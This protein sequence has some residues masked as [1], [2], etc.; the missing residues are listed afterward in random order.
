MKIVTVVGARPQFVKMGVVNRTL[1]KAGVENVVVHTGQH[2][3]PMMSDIFFRE[4]DI[5][6]ALYNLGIN[7]LSHGA[8]TGEMIEALETVFKQHAPDWV[9]VYGD[10]NSTLAAALAASKLRIKIAHVEAGLRSYNWSMPEEINRV[11]TDRLSALLFVPTPTADENLRTEGV[12][13]DGSRRR[14]M[15]TGDVMYDVFL[16][17]QKTLDIANL[18][19]FEVKPKSFVLFT[20][21]REENT[22]AE[23]LRAIMIGVEQTARL[24]MPV[25]FPVHPHTEAVLRECWKP[26]PNVQKLPPL[27]L[28]DM[29]LLTACA[30]TV[31]TDSGGLQKEAYF[32]KT[33]CVTIRSETEW[34]ETLVDGAN[35]LCPEP[36]NIGKALDDAI[37]NI[38]LTWKEY[39][40]DGDAA[41]RIVDGLRYNCNMKFY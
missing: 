18:A 36:E 2:F 34:S 24:G 10:T 19:K 3:S 13:G 39:F 35:R 32:A 33:P 4:L 22:V 28:K 41:R 6:P 8:M 27:G 26:N 25:L 1:E 9:L 20:C 29:H 30:K 23:R 38:N 21:H 15:Y 37:A 16:Q 7:Q 11:V 12:G 17:V 14:I 5:K 40:G 31:I